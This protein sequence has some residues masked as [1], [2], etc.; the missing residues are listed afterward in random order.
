MNTERE[1]IIEIEKLE[2]SYEGVPVLKGIDLKVKKGD[3]ISIIGRS[4][5]G[6]TTLLRCINCLEIFDSGKMKIAGV[7]LQREKGSKKNDKKFRKQQEDVMRNISMPIPDLKSYSDISEDFKIKASKLRS[8]VGMLFQSLNLFP[9]MTVIENVIK[10]PMI[11]QRIDKETARKYARF[12][13]EKV[14]MDKYADRYPH[15]LSGGQCQRVAISRALAMNPKVMLYDEPTSALDPELVEEVLQV[16]R[17]L[18]DE[19]MTQLVVTHTLSFAKNASD[20]VIYMED[21]KF[22][23]SGKPE[24][25]FTNPKDDRT[26]EYLQILRQ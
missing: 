8:N 26:K 13:L 23:E 21:G 11:V 14:G 12:L 17:L 3:L 10:A 1:N 2:K 5:C 25:I 22:V 4:G 7:S 18:H 6:K 19:G 9:H 20:E 15:Q 24:E 16:M